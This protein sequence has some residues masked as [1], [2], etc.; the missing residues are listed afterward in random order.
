MDTQAVGTFRRA[1][2]VG[3][4]AIAGLPKCGGDDGKRHLNEENAT[5]KFETGKMLRKTIVRSFLE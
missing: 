1:G 3:L 2:A 5:L 4:T